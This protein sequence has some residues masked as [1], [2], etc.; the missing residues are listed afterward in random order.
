MY[1]Q[2]NIKSTNVEFSS[3]NTSRFGESVESTMSEW[4]SLLAD[5]EGLDKR[6][7]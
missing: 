1:W 3:L 4:A 7:I 5:T 6:D 2:I